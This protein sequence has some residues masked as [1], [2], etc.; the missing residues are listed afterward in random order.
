MSNYKQLNQAQR[1][2]IE[3]LKKAG[4]SQKEIAAL[5]G[6]SE[7]TISR[8]LKRNQGKK[9][10]RP[11]QAQIKADNRK[12]QAAKA[13]KM[14]PTLILLIEARIR[15]D[16][17]PE[18]VSGQLKDE[19]GI[20]IS[21]E[22]IY[23][24]IWADKRHGGTLHTHLRQYHKQRKKKYGSKDKR[25]QIRN[26]V[27]IEERPAI[28]AEKTRIGDWEIDTVIGQ[29]HQGALVTIVDRVSRYT[30]IKKVDSKHADVVTAAT[31]S[32]L[33]PY[34]DKTL[35][36]TAD[37]GKEFA[38]HESIKEQLGANVY[39]AH[40]YCSW[41]RGLNENTNGLIRQYFTKGSSFQ[42]ITDDEVEAVMNK[43]NHRPRKSL[44]FKTPHAVFFADLLQQAA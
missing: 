40:P 5:L 35:T 24:H 7:S 1:Y 37:N 15:L 11:K 42:N 23:Q 18:Q 44:K 2:Q 31:I 27:S 39:F 12:K 30:L 28:V 9:G 34:L 16:W 6:V 14:T 22:R 21:H 13:L 19:L 25:G 3:I 20:L 17:S 32:L 41:E 43:L 4:K 33:Q 29:N 8:E 10:Y 38:G 36:I 26:R